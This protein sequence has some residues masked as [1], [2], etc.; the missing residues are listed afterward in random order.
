M[1]LL[2][3]S[4]KMHSFSESWSEYSNLGLNLDNNY[5][6]LPLSALSRTTIEKSVHYDSGHRWNMVT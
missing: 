3:V 4:L 1:S 2:N 6:V 5:N